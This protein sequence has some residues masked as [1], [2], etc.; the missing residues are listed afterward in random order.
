V[1]STVERGMAGT[2]TFVDHETE[3]DKTDL[4][5]AIVSKALMFLTLT[6]NNDTVA[7]ALMKRLSNS[8]LCSLSA[9]GKASDMSEYPVSDMMEVEASDKSG[10][11]TSDMPK[12]EA[13]DKSDNSGSPTS[14]MTEDKASDKSESSTSDMPKGDVSDKTGSETSE[15]LKGE[16][17]DKSGS[18]TSDMA[19]EASDKSG[20]ATT[21]I[22]EVEAS[23]KPESSTSD[24]PKDASAKNTPESGHEDTS[25]PA[26]DPSGGGGDTQHE[27]AEKCSSM[28]DHTARVDVF[29]SQALSPELRTDLELLSVYAK[30]HQSAIVANKSSRTTAH[31]CVLD[32]ST[33]ELALT[34]TLQSPIQLIDTKRSVLATMVSL[35]GTSRTP[36]NTGD[37]R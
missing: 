12:G 10:S 7:S 34:A 36:E 1:I 2:F 11:S 14:D 25:T 8:W 37:H 20:S 23:D 15:V 21:D 3:Q 17:S 18:S 28:C 13:T 22:T 19:E 29:L 6:V 27:E 4:C 24:I 32:V 30:Y 26:Q 5:R 33:F 9:E 16:A 35:A 31:K